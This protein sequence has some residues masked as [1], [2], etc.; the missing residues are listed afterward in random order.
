MDLTHLKKH[1][2]YLF[3]EQWEHGSIRYFRANFIGFYGIQQSSYLICSHCHGRPWFRSGNPH[4]DADNIIIA[5]TLVDLFENHPCRLPDDV[6]RV[7]N[8]FW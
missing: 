1:E 4:I 7:I 6:L 3:G 5:E 8:D 2:R